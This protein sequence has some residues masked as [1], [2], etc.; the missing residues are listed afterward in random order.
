MSQSCLFAV[1]LFLHM[2]TVAVDNSSTIVTH[3]VLAADRSTGKV[4]IV[5]V[6]GEVIWELPNQHDIR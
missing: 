3:R 2:T 6:K 4:A 1:I 5:G